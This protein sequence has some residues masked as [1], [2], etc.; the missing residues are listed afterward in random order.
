MPFVEDDIGNVLWLLTAC[1]R[2]PVLREQVAKELRS[3]GF[4]L[5]QIPTIREAVISGRHVSMDKELQPDNSEAGTLGDRLPS[6]DL[7]ADEIAVRADFKA[8]MLA[9]VHRVLK[10]REQKI[11]IL[12]FGFNGGERK[13]LREIADVIGVTHER[14]RQIEGKALNRLQQ[15]SEVRALQELSPEDRG[16][17]RNLNGIMRL[18]FALAFSPGGK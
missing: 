3:K 12:R 15:D 17:V 7:P 4:T 13:T 10:P 2:D 11:L 9:A 8:R 16:Y 18:L 1:E 14:V 5:R 6:D